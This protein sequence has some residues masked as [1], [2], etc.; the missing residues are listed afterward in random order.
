MICKARIYL[1][2]V[3][4]FFLAS[5]ASCGKDSPTEPV[6]QTPARITLSSVEATLSAVGQTIQLTATVLDQENKVISGAVVTWTSTNQSVVKVDT[7]GLV[8]AIQNGY[9]QITATSGS[10][11]ANASIVVAQAPGRIEV[12]P[13][14]STLSALGETV[15]LTY[16]VYDG[17]DEPIPGAGVSWSSDDDTVASVSA[18]GLVTAV[19]N[20]SARITASSDGV[21]KTVDVTVEIDYLAFEREIL[22]ELYNATDGTNWMN[23]TNW[24]TETPLGEWHGIST[25]S[26]GRVNHINLTDN[27]LSGMIPGS[28]GRLLE[29]E[30]LWLGRNH[31]TGFIPS[32]IG[33]LVNIDDLDLSDNQLTGDIPSSLGN[34]DLCVELALSGNRLTGSIPF[35]L[36]QMEKLGLLDLSDNQLTGSIPTSLGQSSIT[37]FYLNNNLL[38]GTIDTA[39]GQLMNLQELILHNNTDLTGPLPRGFANLAHAEFIVVDLRHTNLCAPADEE[40]QTWLDMTTFRGNNCSP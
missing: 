35:S 17:N 2:V 1:P 38:S 28:I 34:L 25:G 40:F 21:S 10:V 22:V 3:V 30:I 16:T 32:S 23:N 18:N 6:P 37:F 24:I 8:T 12:M 11:S 36:G 13:S 5:T 15:Q 14:S 20:G 7:N 33:N 29:V 19:G 26:D 39:F 31:L 9:V 27:G 4:C